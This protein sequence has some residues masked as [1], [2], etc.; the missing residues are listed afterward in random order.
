MWV[1]IYWD[2]EFLPSWH[3]NCP[4]L[5]HF[6]FFAAWN[7]QL[8]VEVPI[9]IL[10]PW[11]KILRIR[12]T[13]AHQPQLTSG[14]RAYVRE[15]KSCLSHYFS[16]PCSS[17]SRAIPDRRKWNL[18][19]SLPGWTLVSYDHTFVNTWS[20]AR[21]APLP[22]RFFRQEY[23][24]ELPF[25]SPGESSQARG[26]TEASTWQAGSLPLSHL[27]S[28]FLSFWPVSHHSISHSGLLEPVSLI[29]DSFSSTIFSPLF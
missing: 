1:A 10:Q 3:R 22:R 12:E 4:F 2:A 28:P 15:M 5:L 23:W 18:L 20:V 17:L 13:S 29:L 24:S 14:C 8:M 6:L 27:G 11:G 25:P 16:G 19:T 21:Q 9:V 26:W 7:S